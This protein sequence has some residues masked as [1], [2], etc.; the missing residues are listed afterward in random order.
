M[1]PPKQIVREVFQK[2]LASID[3]PAVMNHKIQWEHSKLLLPSCCIDLSALTR[4]VIIGIGKAAHSMV[5]GLVAQFPAGSS[6]TGIVAA[7]TPSAKLVPGLEYFVCG[8]PIPNRDSLGSAE[9]IL[10]LLGTCDSH[11]LVFFLLSGGG[12]ALV[13]LPLEPSMSLEDVQVVH[14]TLVTCGAP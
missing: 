6:F 5:E 10:R 3:I 4:M 13:D 9:A 1:P 2:T 14:Q 12:S 8:H 11:T 7:P